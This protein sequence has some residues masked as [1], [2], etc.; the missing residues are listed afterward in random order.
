MFP[1]IGVPPNHPLLIGFSIINHLFLGYPYFWKHP[2][3]YIYISHCV[4][5]MTCLSLPP[6]S[7]SSEKIWPSPSYLV[8]L[9]R[10]SVG[11]WWKAWE[12][13]TPP[14]FN[15]EPEVMMVS[16]AGI[17]FFEGLIFRWTMLNFRGVWQW[18][19]HTKKKK[20]ADVGGKKTQDR[21]GPCLG[22][23][24]LNRVFLFSWN[25]EA[26]IVTHVF[27]LRTVFNQ[28]TIVFFSCCLPCQGVDGGGPGLRFGIL[29]LFAFSFSEQLVEMVERPNKNLFS[30]VERWVP[31]PSPRV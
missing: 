20:T 23:F 25:C 30:T 8:R 16:K 11:S 24:C 31:W 28:P 27:L 1:K 26:Y 17:T 14:K 5:T 10:S 18:N 15:M 22:S 3:I 12:K 2:Y 21:Y 13:T 9:G 29:I 19:S 7:H 6:G 4:L